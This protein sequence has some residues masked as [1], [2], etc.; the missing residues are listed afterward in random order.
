[1][2]G[3]VHEVTTATTGGCELV[4]FMLANWFSTESKR[5]I[6]HDN[7]FLYFEKNRV[8]VAYKLQEVISK[9]IRS[10]CW[11]AWLAGRKQKRQG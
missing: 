11:D 2:V 4:T 5:F 1:M 6:S 9:A 7:Y 3:S 10:G 8:V